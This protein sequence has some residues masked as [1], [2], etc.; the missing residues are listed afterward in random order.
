MLERINDAF[1]RAPPRSV[2]SLRRES[3][4]GQIETL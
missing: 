1:N 4:M 3:R 2:Q